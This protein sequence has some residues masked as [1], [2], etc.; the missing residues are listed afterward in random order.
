MSYKEYEY[1]DIMKA[2]GKSRSSIKKWRITVER[3][4]GHEFKKTRMR[5]SRRRVQ[6]IYQ[7]TEEE[8]EKFIKLS[9]R[10]DETNNMAQSV[11]EIWG[12]LKA[13]EE[14]LLKENV[15]KLIDNYNALAEKNKTLSIKVNILE[16]G[17]KK[18]KEQLSVMEETK[19]QG[20]FS[21]IKKKDK[22]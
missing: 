10:I 22:R 16:H 15:S 21:K 17:Y 7:F 14:H 1:E 19:K 9:K 6:D 12:D 5:V 13:R 8:Y 3:L 18:L 4:S 11:V 2:T 20:F